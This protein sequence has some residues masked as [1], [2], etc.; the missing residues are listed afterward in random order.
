MAAAGAVVAAAGVAVALWAW[1]RSVATAPIPGMV[2]QT[3]IRIAPDSTGRLGRLPVAPGQH[4]RKGDLLAVLDNP[5]LAASVEEAEA[6]LGRARADRARIYSGVRAEEV[7][8]AAQSVK[9]AEANLLLAQ[10]EYARTAPLAQRDFA[11]RQ[12]LDESIASV[13][14]A[15]AD[16]DLKHAQ[17]DAARAGPTVEERALA[18]AKVTLAEATVADLQAKLDKTQLMAPADGTI[19]LQVAEPGEVISPGQPVMTLEADGQRWF[20]FTI[21][22]DALQGL[23]MGRTISLATDDGRRIEARVSEMRPLGE[24]ATWRAARAVNDHDLN[25]LWLRLDPVTPQQELQPGATVWL[26]GRS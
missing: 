17:Y 24:F 2:R 23:A 5:E 7:G 16:L 26:Q 15:Q 9:T 22:E 4:V 14:S 19:G 21:R 6:D 3:E 1:P 20:A 8:M 11:A 12:Q 10:K 25:S 13:A 18:D